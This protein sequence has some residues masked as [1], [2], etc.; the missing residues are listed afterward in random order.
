MWFFLLNFI[1][2]SPDTLWNDS[3]EDGNWN[4]NPRWYLRDGTAEIS[5]TKHLFLL[6][7]NNN[8]ANI[9]TTGDGD[10]ENNF[11]M[12]F[13]TKIFDNPYSN[14]E[15]DWLIVRADNTTEYMVLFDPIKEK[16]YIFN[17][18][19]Y[20]DSA[21]SNNILLGSK[22]YVALQVIDNYIFVACSLST[23]TTPPSNWDLIY[24]KANIDTNNISDTLWVGGWDIDTAGIAGLMW[25]DFVVQTPDT[26]G[27]KETYVNSPILS[28][29]AYPNPFTRKISIKYSLIDF[30]ENYNLELVI[31]D[32]LGRNVRIIPINDKYSKI[33]EVIWDGRDNTGRKVP[34]GIYSCV[35]KLG[36]YKKN[37]KLTLIR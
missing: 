1:I 14:T 4:S 27:I 11:Y 26:S 8:R 37:L 25:D 12:T 5:D 34:S 2:T 3:F 20:V 36:R 10:H 7:D 19:V 15:K 21:T 23:F 9:G 35:L 28:L 13:K 6:G 22:F 24:T 31:Y 32:F 18:S 17:D 33:N 30:Y 16:I 29:K